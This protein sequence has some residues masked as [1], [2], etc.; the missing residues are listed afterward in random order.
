MMV[1]IWWWKCDGGNLLVK[2]WLWKFSGEQM[3]VTI[4]CWKFGGEFLV[5]IWWWMN[6]GGH[7]A[8]KSLDANYF[9]EAMEILMPQLLVTGSL[10]STHPLP[11]NSQAVLTL[12]QNRSETHKK[13][14]AAKKSSEQGIPGYAHAW[15]STCCVSGAMRYVFHHQIYTIIFTPHNVNHQLSTINI[16]PHTSHHQVFTNK[17]SSWKFHQQSVGPPKGATVGISPQS[18]ARV[19]CGCCVR[20]CRAVAE[21][22]ALFLPQRTVGGVTVL[23]NLGSHTILGSFTSHPIPHIVPVKARWSSAH[24]HSRLHRAR[25]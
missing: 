20:S 13:T 8:K 19:S 4:W 9:R 1:D 14:S 23:I 3:A 24:V 22:C 12:L 15:T 18:L 7:L 2:I 6:G 21:H 11:G 10:V 25:L 17:K 5:E 16:P